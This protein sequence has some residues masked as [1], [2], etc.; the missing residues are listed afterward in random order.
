GKGPVAGTL[1]STVARQLPPFVTPSGSNGEVLKVITSS[2]VTI[3]YLNIRDGSHPQHSDDGVDFKT[4]TAGRLFCNCITNNE[5][6]A[7]MVAGCCNQ[8]IQNLVI[9][10][11]NGIR[12]SS[13]TK[14]DVFQDNTTK[15]DNLPSI[16]RTSDLA[17]R[18]TGLIHK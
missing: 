7:D 16:D 11:Q 3:K 15:N 13:G 17:G 9:S 1:T 18:R 5:D 10:N 6:A 8:F 4:S 14:F 2:R 12:A